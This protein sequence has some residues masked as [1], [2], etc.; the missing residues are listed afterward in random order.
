M[1]PFTEALLRGNFEELTEKG[2]KPDEQRRCFRKADALLDYIAKVKPTEYVQG[3]CCKKMNP[4]RIEGLGYCLEKGMPLPKMQKLSLDI[5]LN[6]L[7]MGDELLEKTAWL[8]KRCPAL[9]RAKYASS[10]QAF[11][12]DIHWCFVRGHVVPENSFESFKIGQNPVLSRNDTFSEKC[13]E[14]YADPI[15]ETSEYQAYRQKRESKDPFVCWIRKT[16]AGRKYITEKGALYRAI[17]QL[18]MEK[19]LELKVNKALTSQLLL[20][21]KTI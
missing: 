21:R 15:F 20:K 8:Y 10:R 5:V 16:K 14:L 9:F 6:L 19:E 1:R 18:A 7:S 3:V 2:W 4:Q 12:K 11:Q 17:E 13:A